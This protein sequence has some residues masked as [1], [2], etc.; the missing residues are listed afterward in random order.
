MSKKKATG[1]NI[2][3]GS[4]SWKQNLDMCVEIYD[5][6]LKKKQRHT[7]NEKLNMY[8]DIFNKSKQYFNP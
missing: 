7:T 5:S 3:A 8:L 4:R 1:T 2:T 6:K